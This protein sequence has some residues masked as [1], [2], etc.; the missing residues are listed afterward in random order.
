MGRKGDAVLY[1][2]QGYDVALNQSA[3]LKQL[4]E[5]EE[6]LVKENTN[7]SNQEEHSNGSSAPL[8]VLERHSICEIETAK[9]PNKLRVDSEISSES[10]HVSEVQS[11]LVPECHRQNGPV[12]KIKETKKFDSKPNGTYKKLSSELES[13]N[14]P[15]EE[16]R[17]KVNTS[18]VSNKLNNKNS[19]EFEGSDAV[20]KNQKVC[21]AR[22]S[23]TKS[24]SL[25]F[26]LSRGIAEVCFYP[27]ICVQLLFP[28]CFSNGG[29]L[30]YI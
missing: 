2:K 29:L 26:R 18:K 9:D 10:D 19:E 1:W 13:L 25:D 20:K 28:N 5:L 23:K 8:T 22:I 17:N 3:D 6:L 11:K 15:S 24:I 16:P 27:S 30:C 14:K 7:G 4:L 21:V 12:E